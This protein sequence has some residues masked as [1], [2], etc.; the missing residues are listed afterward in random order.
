[1]RWPTTTR[2]NVEILHA[3]ARHNQMESIAVHHVKVRE[4]RS[5]STAIAD[6]PHAAV[7][8][9]LTVSQITQITQIRS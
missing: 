4:K 6:I 1:M 5:R 7:I 9:D 3:L 8:F 2:T